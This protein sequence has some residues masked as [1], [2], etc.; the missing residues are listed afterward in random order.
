MRAKSGRSSS[1][2]YLLSLLAIGLFLIG[3]GGGQLV[4]VSVKSGL[5]LVTLWA[6]IAAGC[7]A[8]AACA[9]GARTLV[10]GR[11]SQN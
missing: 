9:L 3:Y 4:A 6:L 1:P 7:S 11:R 5:Y 8:L 2:T 10:S